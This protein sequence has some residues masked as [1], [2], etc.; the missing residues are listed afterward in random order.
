MPLV[1]GVGVVSGAAVRSMSRIEKMAGARG[2]IRACRDALGVLLMVAA[3]SAAAEPEHGATSRPAEAANAPP[4]RSRSYGAN[5]EPEPPGY[6]RPAPGLEVPGRPGVSWLDFGAEHYTRYERRDE[7]YR[8][9]DLRRYDQFLM[10]SRAYLGVR[11]IVD[12]LRLGVEFNDVRQF[13]GLFPENAAEVDEA[14]LLQAFAELHFSDALG[15]D[16]PLRLVAG[17]M[18]L[19]LVDR[20]LVARNRWRNT[21]NAFDGFRLQLGRPES[22][23]QVDAFAAQPVDRFLR[24]RD[25]PNEERWL[26]GVVGTWRRW[27]SYATLAPYYFVLD[28]DR[29]RQPPFDREIHTLGL[30][31]FGPVAGTRFDYDTDVAFQIGSDGR[32]DQRAFAAHGELG[33]TLPHL[34]RPRWSVSGSYASGDRHP[35]DGVTERFDPLFGSARFLSNTNH[36]TWQNIIMARARVEVQPRDGLWIDASYGPYWLASDSDAWAM[37]GRVDPSGSSG[38]FLGQEADVRVRWA[39]SRHVELIFGY[40]YFIPGAFVEHTGPADDSDY[41]YFQTTLRF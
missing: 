25:R 13:N 8:R 17:R 34:W 15:K 33:Y 5:L 32:L 40:S 28:E 31:V 11:E 16:R 24:Q 14:D 27:H 20:R 21:V 30:H 35:G 6:V 22:D 37:A 10:R 12:P 4:F 1:N 2:S 39:L 19:D 9:P 23:W 18:T 41:F 36:F 38:D 3:A 26:Y 7:D 29:K